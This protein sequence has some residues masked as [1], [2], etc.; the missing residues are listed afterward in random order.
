MFTLAARTVTEEGG[1]CQ[2]AKEAREE[3]VMALPEPLET[4]PRRV[5]E[6]MLLDLPTSPTWYLVEAA[7]H[8][9]TYQ[10]EAQAAMAA[11]AGESSS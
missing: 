3:E 8:P 11:M 10:A 4:V 2:V 7:G 9:T 5:K 6:E 1:Q